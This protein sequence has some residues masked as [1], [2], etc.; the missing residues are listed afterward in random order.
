MRDRSGRG[1]KSRLRFDEGTASEKKFKGLKLKRE[2]L[3]KRKTSAI[4]KVFKIVYIKI[5]KVSFDWLS[6]F[7]LLMLMQ[8]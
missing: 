7:H 3:L 6:L 1:I 5:R 2:E 8:V 4:A